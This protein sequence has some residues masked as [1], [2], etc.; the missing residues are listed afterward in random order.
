MDAREIMRWLL[1]ELTRR[2][3]WQAA[4]ASERQAAAAAQR[5]TALLHTHLTEGEWAQLT[6]RGSLE[7]ASP[8]TPGRRYS[9][10]RAGGIVTV[11]QGGRPVM[12]LCVGPAQPLPADDV[13]LL[14]LLLI[15]GDEPAYLATA[16]RFPLR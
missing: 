7:V 11:Y 14:H 6:R 13:V 1:R 15:R 3:V 16:N 12:Q 5:A 10:P 9:I 8:S 2:S 4:S